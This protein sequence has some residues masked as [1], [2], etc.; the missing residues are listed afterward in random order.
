MPAPPLVEPSASNCAI[1]DRISALWMQDVEGG[2][3]RGAG[4]DNDCDPVV[5]TEL[6][7]EPL[8]SPLDQRQFV[9]VV[10]GAGDID[11]EDEVAG[12]SSGL[13]DR[14]GGDADPR[15]PMP[16]IPRTVSDLNVD[17]E[18]MLARAGRRR[19][20]IGE[21]IEELLDA[22][23]VRRRQHLLAEEA[24]DV[25]IAGRIDV[26]R[27]G[28]L[29]LFLHRLERVVDD[30]CVHFGVEYGHERRRCGGSGGRHDRVLKGLTSEF[31]LDGGRSCRAGG[32]SSA[33]RRFV[34]V[35]STRVGGA[36][37]LMGR[38]PEAGGKFSNCMVPGL[39]TC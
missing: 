25:G 35:T 28:R 13:V 17:R 20:A 18:R 15:Q 39:A 37:E 30:A 1:T 10:H 3:A 8:Q 11:Q 14:P 24:A 31:S 2:P 22:D 12:R 9:R 7:D 34:S 33:S 23:R 36:L 32:E 5:F 21:V 4:I 26:D 19:I 27:E 29:R 6:I 38:S 16:G